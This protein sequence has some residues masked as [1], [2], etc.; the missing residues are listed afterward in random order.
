MANSSVSELHNQSA[1][2][3]LQLIST[4]RDGYLARH[5]PCP[6]DEL[7]HEQENLCYGRGTSIQHVPWR[8]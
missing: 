4:E 8:S 2:R 3:G 6:R 1:G 5:L 7:N